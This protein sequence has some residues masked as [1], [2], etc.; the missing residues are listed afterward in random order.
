MNST[1]LE[2]FKQNGFLLLGRV[3]TDEEVDRF[4]G[5]YD[6]DR[7]ERGYFWRL[8]GSRGHQTV[9]CDPLITC[10]GIDDLLRH[11]RIL[12]HI[13]KLIGDSLCLSEACFRHMAPH[14]GEPSQGWHRDFAHDLDHPLRTAFVHAMVYLTDVHEETHCFSISPESIDDPILE[15]EAQLKRGGV[16]DIHGPAG[17]VVLF[18]LS[19]LHA[20]TVRQTSHERK[21]LQTYYGR[22]SGAV[23]SHYTTLPARLW[24]DHSDPEVR[25]FYGNLNEK[26][27]LFSEAFGGDV[28]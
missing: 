15:T 13:E 27:K 21:T 14:A 1:D 20:A 4:R 12:P 6:R 8:T 18:N 28:S 25:G 26:S 24:R 17:T 9:N 5:L 23:L 3:L 11:P 19:V 16:V 10:P 22:R 2:F 7:S